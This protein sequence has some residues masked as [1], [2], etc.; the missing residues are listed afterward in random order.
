MGGTEATWATPTVVGSSLSIGSQHDG[1]AYAIG[2][3]IVDQRRKN[4]A[5]GGASA[6]YLAERD[7]ASLI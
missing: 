1:L 5:V 7:V 2:A 3:A 4:A 6:G